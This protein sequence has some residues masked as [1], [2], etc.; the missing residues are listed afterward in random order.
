EAQAE[1]VVDQLQ[2]LA[3]LRE[4]QLRLLIGAAA[5]ESLAI[6]EDIRKDITAPAAAGLDQMVTTAQHQRFEFKAL[7]LGIRAKLAQRD[8]ERAN[9]LPRLSA[10]ATADYARPNPRVFPQVDEFKCTWQAGVQLTWTLNDAL[11]SR[12]SDARIRAETN[13]LREDRE[14]LE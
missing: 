3:E 4:E 11:I 7:D 8:A 1:Q 2:N 14:N 13:E 10:F 12:T 6:G 9:L 5:T